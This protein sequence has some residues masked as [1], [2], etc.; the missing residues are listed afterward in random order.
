M[1]T[2]LSSASEAR[3]RPL[4]PGG[5]FPPP[6]DQAAELQAGVG[7]GDADARLSRLGDGPV[8]ELVAGDLDVAGA[9]AVALVAVGAR[10]HH[11][12][13]QPPVTVVG[14]R[15]SRGDV[16]QPRRPGARRVE[17]H[18]PHAAADR[19]PG[20]VVDVAADIVPDGRR[21]TAAPA[22][23]DRLFAGSADALHGRGKA[24]C[25]ERAGLGLLQRR[26]ADSLERAEARAALL[27]ER[28]VARHHDGEGLRQAAGGV[29][30]QQRVV[31]MMPDLV[32]SSPYLVMPWRGAAAPAPV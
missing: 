7:R 29:G 3:S 16:D 1:T 17:L 5:P 30:H 31:Q 32:H 2:S 27:A 11:G 13:F 14:H 26:A 24:A 15:L 20:D 23:R 28:D 22:P 21:K 25:L 8:L 12:Q 4:A 10:Q 18:L 19:P 6:R 9:E